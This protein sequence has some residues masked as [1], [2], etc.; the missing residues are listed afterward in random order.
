MPINNGSMAKWN[1]SHCSTITFDSDSKSAEKW[2]FPASTESPKFRLNII[3]FSHNIEYWLTH[4]CSINYDMQSRA[5]QQATQIAWFNGKL[6]LCELP[7]CPYNSKRCRWCRRT[8][9]KECA[10]KLWIKCILVYW[11]IGMKYVKTFFVCLLLVVVRWF[12]C[13][14][15]FFNFKMKTKK[16]AKQSKATPYKT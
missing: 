11:Y 13:L 14:I 4:V 5:E 9:A 7:L 1:K 10:N 8:L 2:W 16:Q 3:S 12:G 6:F 15:F